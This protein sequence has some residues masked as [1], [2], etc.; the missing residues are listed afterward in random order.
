MRKLTR[1]SIILAIS[2]VMLGTG[3]VGY[4]DD[5]DVFGIKIEQRALDLLT[6]MSQR[7]AEVNGSADIERVISMKAKIIFADLIQPDQLI[8]PFPDELLE[9]IPDMI[10][11]TRIELFRAGPDLVRVNLTSNLAEL[12]FAVTSSESLAVLPEDGIFAAINIP[13]MLPDKLMLQDDGGLL[14]LLNLL[15]GIPYGSLLRQTSDDIFGGEDIEF[16]QVA[17][18][19]VRAVIRYWGKDKT[20]AGIVHVV[21]ILTGSAAPY[22]QSIK[23]LVLEDT[24]DLYMISIE[25]ARETQVFIFIDEINTSPV[26]SEADFKIDTSVLTEVGEAELL[27][28]LVSN[29]ATSPMIESPIAADLTASSHIVA[30]SGTLTIATNGF[31]LQDRENELLLEVEYR[32]PSGTWEPLERLEYAGLV[33]LGHWNAVFVPG[34]TAELGLYSFRARYTDSSGND[35]GWL[36]VLDMVKVTP[37]PPRVV[38]TKPVNRATE[39]PITMQI[40]ITFTKPMDKKS[41]EDN[42]SVGTWYRNVQGSFSWDGN[43]LIFSPSDDLKYDTEYLVMLTGEAKDVDGLGLDGNYDSRS[44]GVPYDDYYWTFTTTSAPPTLAIMWQERHIK[45]GDRFDLKLM[46]K[47]VTEMHRFGF[48]LVFDPE[49]L[50]VEKIDKASFL[51]WQPSWRP[52]PEDLEA[53]DIYGRVTV[54]NSAGIV[55]IACDSTRPGGV[56][57]SGEIAD[58]TVRAVGVGAAALRFDSVSMLDARGRA[59]SVELDA[60]DIQVTEFHPM[61]INQDGVVNILDFVAIES[62]ED[63]GS[64]TAPHLAQTRLEQ[65]YPNPFN[66]ET[67]IPYQL[68]QPSYVTIRI[69]RST[70]ELTRTLDLGTREAGFYADKM[71]AAYWDG[72]ND[73]GEQ[74]SSGVYFYTIQAGGFAATRKMIV[75]K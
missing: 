10:V 6:L 44:D 26:L 38:R 29:I 34:E 58:I 46:A 16:G 48:K 70:G 2:A 64:Q 57:G 66:P 68:A 50:E 35:S 61:D 15:G 45:K 3:M 41:V 9:H 28:R 5:D 24:L 60:P 39:V 33:P 4:A 25:D 7:M 14:T 59:V 19:D 65:N 53:T 74:V 1:W 40:T 69:Y 75:A 12:Q 43:I 20:D 47:D 54:D 32:S 27:S 21:N 31:D 63:E 72:R 71:K 36:E 8:G 11:E 13:Q 51:S 23:I 55:T 30:R 52:G 73:A 42:F 67:W 49:V 17:P 22:H 62:A 56:S 18:E 37:D